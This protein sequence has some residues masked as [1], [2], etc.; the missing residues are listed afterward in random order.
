MLGTF[1]KQTGILPAV[2]VAILNEEGEILLQRR[3]DRNQWGVLSGHVEFGESVEEAAVREVWEE[4]GLKVE[5]HRLI[6][7]Y[8]EPITQ[9][10][11][12]PTGKTVQYVTVYFEACLISPFTDFSGE[13]TLEIRFFKPTSLPE[14][15]LTMSPYWLS[16]A[17]SNR[18]GYVR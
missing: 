2:A 17:L 15:L 4:T 10:Y 11:S 7:V 1:M 16:D 6:G 14:N 18:G 9:T 5:V 13:E 8:S 12:Y 3:R